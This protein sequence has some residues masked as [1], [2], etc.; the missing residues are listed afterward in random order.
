MTTPCTTRSARE[1]GWRS[2]RDGGSPPHGLRNCVPCADS[3]P[4]TRPRLPPKAKIP[5]H[6][7]IRLRF[8]LDSPLEGAGFEPSVPRINAHFP[9]CRHR[10][11][12]AAWSGDLCVEPVT[13]RGGGASC[14]GI[15][16]PLVAG[17]DDPRR[18]MTRIAPLSQ[19]WRPRQ[20]LRAS[21]KRVAGESC[22]RGHNRCR[23]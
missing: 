18:A 3:S 22:R 21:P 11:D 20:A 10:P 17:C 14:Y 23:R 2:I 6:E 16:S 4:F 8:A 12:P 19:A 15:S 7:G 5:N 1:K 13:F 9:K